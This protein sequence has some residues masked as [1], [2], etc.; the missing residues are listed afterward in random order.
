MKEDLFELGITRQA[1]VTSK[2]TAATRRAIVGTLELVAD[3]GRRD[4]ADLRLVT[5]LRFWGEI[6]VAVEYGRMWERMAPS[7]ATGGGSSSRFY[8]PHHMHDAKAHPL[9]GVS[10]LSTSHSD[11]LATRL[12]DLL[13]RAPS[14]AP[15]TATET[16]ALRLKESFY[17]QFLVHIDRRGDTNHPPESD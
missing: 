11:R 1:F 10:L 12:V 2:P 9:T 13:S 5:L 17:D 15:F 7:F 6:L 14:G 4:D 8:Y 3:A 16:R